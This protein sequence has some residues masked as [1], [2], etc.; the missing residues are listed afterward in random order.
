MSPQSFANVN[1]NYLEL[2]ACR[3]TYKGIDL[4]GTS[5]NVVVKMEQAL[6]DIKVDQY[7]STVID[8]RVSGFKYTVDLEIDEIKYKDNWKIIFPSVLVPEQGGQKS[9]YFD[10]QMS[11][12]QRSNAGALVLHPLS[13]PDTDKSEDFFFWLASAEAKTDFTYSPSE[14]VKLKISFTIYPDFTTTPARFFMFGDP[15]VGLIAASAGAATA[16]GGNVGNGTITAITAFSGFSKTET[17]SLQCVTPGTGG[18]FSVSG[19]LSGPLGL[20]PVGLTFNSTV[21]AFTVNGGGTPFALNDT[22]TIN[23]LAANYG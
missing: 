20:A 18:Q 13:V 12:S 22:F 11:Y 7:G 10:S 5:G 15:A 6:S 23:T 8:K 9:V 16:G 14:Q 2:S 3:V 21:I 17:I 4:G 1:P 19:S